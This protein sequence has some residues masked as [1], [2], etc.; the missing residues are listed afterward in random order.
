MTTIAVILVLALLAGLTAFQALLVAG[1]P[2][3]HFAWGGQH[4][5]LPQQLR[6][7]SAI[8]IV[9]YAIFAA[10]VLDRAGLISVFPEGV[11][12]WA[13][14]V[15]AGYSLLGIGMNLISRS[16]PERNTMAPVAAALCVLFVLIAMS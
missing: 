16:K 4:R 13:I 5:I 12:Q 14:W 6:I 2:F 11:R 1:M 15:L 3:G 9:L 7:G 10:I 8:S